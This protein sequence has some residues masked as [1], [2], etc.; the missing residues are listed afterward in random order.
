MC[1]Y[2]NEIVVDQGG[3]SI[4][5]AGDDK[6]RH[7]L[8]TY[9]VSPCVVVTG[10]DKANGI[11]FLCHTNILSIEKSLYPVFDNLNLTTDYDIK[12][13]GGISVLSLWSIIT[14]LI[15]SSV[16]AYIIF[17]PGKETD[18]ILPFI[19][20]GLVLFVMFFY[21]EVVRIIIKC[22]IRHKAKGSIEVHDD[23]YS[24]NA[25]MFIFRGLCSIVNPFIK[26]FR[27]PRLLDVRTA[28]YYT[29]NTADNGLVTSG[30]SLDKDNHKAG[31]SSNYCSL[32][33]S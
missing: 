21:S 1:F 20:F 22:L 8:A 14:A 12:L 30:Y 6:E 27:F 9:K 29:L 19:A 5:Y 26:L 33:T 28:K 13:H 25:E 3:C 11:G 7:I 10:Y 18:S 2:N 31:C 32:P 16:V 15:F 24:I 4:T 17:Y 23:E